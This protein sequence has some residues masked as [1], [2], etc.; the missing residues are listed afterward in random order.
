MYIP[1]RKGTKKVIFFVPFNSMPQQSCNAN[2]QSS[3][4]RSNTAHITDLLFCQQALKFGHAVQHSWIPF[5]MGFLTYSVIQKQ[6][7]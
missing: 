7:G 6:I 2:F 5:L 3:R 1:H 4:Q